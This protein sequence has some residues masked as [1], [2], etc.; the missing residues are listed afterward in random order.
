MVRKIKPDI[1][2]TEEPAQ[3]KFMSEIEAACCAAVLFTTFCSANDIS[4]VPM[5]EGPNAEVL[6]S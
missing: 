4:M 6:L 1:V 3:F 2:A 5:E